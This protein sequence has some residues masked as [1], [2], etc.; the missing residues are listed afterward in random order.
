MSLYVTN[1]SYLYLLRLAAHSLLSPPFPDLNGFYE[2]WLDQFVSNW[3]I[4]QTSVRV[5]SFTE[6][7]LLK[8]ATFDLLIG[9]QC[10]LDFGGSGI[11]S[12]YSDFFLRLLS[13]RSTLNFLFF[14]N[15]RWTIKI[16]RFSV[17]L[18][19]VPRR[20]HFDELTDAIK[21]ILFLLSDASQVFLLF[22]FLCLRYLILVVI[23]HDV[24]PLIFAAINLD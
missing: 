19:F 7:R 17:L 13:L 8:L 11:E 22:S 10:M 20:I 14:F 2:W 23:S 15:Q 1:W 4:E 12:S 24:S 21:V 3:V 18:I 6:R 16:N 9:R 5:S